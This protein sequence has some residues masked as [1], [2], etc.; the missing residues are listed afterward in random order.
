MSSAILRDEQNQYHMDFPGNATGDE[1]ALLIASIIFNDMVT[2]YTMWFGAFDLLFVLHLLDHGAESREQ[3][4]LIP[5]PVHSSSIRIDDIKRLSLCY[6]LRTT[7]LCTSVCPLSL[8]TTS[9]SHLCLETSSLSDSLTN[10][11]MSCPLYNFF[12]QFG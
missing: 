9:V 1:K 11:C 2:C 6:L 7:V 4:R 10:W 3:Q 5:D 8:E 12:F